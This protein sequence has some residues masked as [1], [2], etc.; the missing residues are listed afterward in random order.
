M[1]YSIR[2]IE[3]GSSREVELCRVGSKPEEVVKGLKQ[4]TLTIETQL[5]R[6]KI[7]KYNSIRV[8]ELSNEV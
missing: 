1:T 3:Y 4:K 7:R 8:V 5:K 6:Y 2:V